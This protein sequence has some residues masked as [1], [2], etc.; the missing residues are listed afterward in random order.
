[1]IHHEY[2]IGKICVKYRARDVERREKRVNIWYLDEIVC[3]LC[4][5]NG[6][7]RQR[8][9]N[10]GWDQHTMKCAGEQ[11]NPMHESRLSRF[12]VSW[13]LDSIHRGPR[14][15][16]SPRFHGAQCELMRGRS[17]RLEAIACVNPGCCGEGE[18]PRW[19]ARLRDRLVNANSATGSVRL[20]IRRRPSIPAATFRAIPDFLPNRLP[21]LSP[22]ERQAAGLAYL[23]RQVRVVDH[24][25]SRVE[26]DP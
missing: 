2:C 6:L 14:K 20:H 21:F 1:M 25:K 10:G 22:A 11:A 13:R 4:V 24:R 3:R 15:R 12:R 26:K 18:W 5:R 17:N 16:T 7:R 8:M 9:W 19:R 23:F